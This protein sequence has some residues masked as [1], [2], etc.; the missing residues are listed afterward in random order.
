VEGAGEDFERGALGV[1][2]EVSAD[3]AAQARKL[4]GEQ[5][6]HVRQQLRYDVW[7][8]L[9]ER[10]RLRLDVIVIVSEQSA[11]ALGHARLNVAAGTRACGPANVAQAAKQR[12]AALAMLVPAGRFVHR[13]ENDAAAAKGLVTGACAVADDAVEALEQRHRRGKRGGQA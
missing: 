11:Q 7:A 5:R 8:T 4:A 6:L 10:L 2:A 12:A 3:A 9:C 13:G 1:V